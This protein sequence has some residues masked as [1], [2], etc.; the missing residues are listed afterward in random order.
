MSTPLSVPCALFDDAPECASY[1]F[2]LLLLVVVSFSIAISIAFVVPVVS[3]AAAIV[4]CFERLRLPVLCANFYIFGTL[5]MYFRSPQTDYLT[6]RGWESYQPDVLTAWSTVA[7]FVGNFLVVVPLAR[8]LNIG[9]AVL[10]YNTW[11]V[12]TS[13][14]LGIDSLRGFVPFTI[15][16]FLQQS[17][18]LGEM[19]LAFAALLQTAPDG[20]E[21]LYVMCAMGCLIAGASGMPGPLAAWVYSHD[22]A[23]AQLVRNCL[24]LSVAL[25]TS[26]AFVREP[27]VGVRSDSAPL[28]LSP[29]LVLFAIGSGLGSLVGYGSL[30][31]PATS[32]GDAA[33]V[34]DAA[35][36]SSAAPASSSSSSLSLASPAQEIDLG[37]LS[38]AAGNGVLTALPILLVAAVAG[39][40]LRHRSDRILFLLSGV[41]M[42]LS[43]S[44]II[45]PGLGGPAVSPVLTAVSSL[46]DQL[47]VQ[48]AFMALLFRAALASEGILSRAEAALLASNVSI[49][50]GLVPEAVGYFTSGTVLFQARNVWK[51]GFQAGFG[52]VI[53]GLGLLVG[54]T[55][56]L[57]APS[58]AQKQQPG[59]PLF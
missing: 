50:I 7:C 18:Y 42:A 16:T 46:A 31:P 47:V 17:T 33:P 13:V 9:Y 36:S 59:A 27:P 11:G 6:A 21:P 32:D 35:A 34:S 56:T 28:R 25:I 19:T 52:G 57:L 3:K 23:L 45:S 1:R 15:I 14:F 41:L 29:A 38:A 4:E 20:N 12:I 53:V 49:C 2:H 43:G 8:R 40:I 5:T 24:M 51:P 39:L 22:L 58:G 48:A 55:G 26:L 37:A 10:A 54:L 44:L 30:A